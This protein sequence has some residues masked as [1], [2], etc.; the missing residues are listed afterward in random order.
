[1][2]CKFCFKSLDQAHS[3]WYCDKTRMFFTQYKCTICK[4]LTTRQQEQQAETF[5]SSEIDKLLRDLPTL[6]L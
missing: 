5:S 1:M 2:K 6:A 4:R 3:G